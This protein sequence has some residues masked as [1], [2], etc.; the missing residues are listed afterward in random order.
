MIVNDDASEFLERLR[1]DQIKQGYRTD[2]C[3]G[4]ESPRRSDS[5]F[6]SEECELVFLQGFDIDMEESDE[7]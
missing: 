6:C 1:R 4:C 3:A 7:D 2:L 5:H